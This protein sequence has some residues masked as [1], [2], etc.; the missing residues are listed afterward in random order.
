VRVRYDERVRRFLFTGCCVVLLVASS[1]AAAEPG[2]RAPFPSVSLRTLDGSGSVAVDGFRGRPVLL[3]FWASWCGPCRVELPELEKLYK[4]LLGDGFVL[5]TVNVDTL[6]AIAD[7]FLEQ[8]GVS[9][10]VYR[11]DHKDL[12][13]L[14]INALPTNILLDREGRTVMF[15]T[16]YSPTV[17]DS[18]RRLVRE[19]GGAAGEPRGAQGS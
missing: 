12:I 6:P 17:P 14:D 13:T 5:L 1:A 11:M 7:R 9:V 15:S 4:E 19:M 18:I 16:G 2:E 10:P 3:S 8:L